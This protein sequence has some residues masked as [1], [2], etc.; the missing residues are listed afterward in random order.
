MRLVL[1]GLVLLLCAGAVVLATAGDD[2]AKGKE[3]KIVFD[4]AF[5]LVEGGDF[6]VGGVTAG[7]TSEFEA[8]KGA[9]PK[10]EV[11]AK[12]TEPGLEALHTDATCAIRPQS[13]I[14]EY[15]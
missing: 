6:R 9:P 11:T 14:G 2:E 1:I 15:Y 7:Q 13:L 10:A 12:V 5:G 3:Y 4:N 8:T